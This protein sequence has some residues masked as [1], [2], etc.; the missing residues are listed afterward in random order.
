M[1]PKR[2]SAR[3][4][5]EHECDR[6]RSKSCRAS[7]WRSASPST[8][9]RALSSGEYGRAVVDA[10]GP[11]SLEPAGRRSRASSRAQ[12]RTRQFADGRQHPRSSRRAPAISS[13]LARTGPSF[14]AGNGSPGQVLHDAGPPTTRPMAQIATSPDSDAPLKGPCFAPLGVRGSAAPLRVGAKCW[15][16]PPSRLGAGPVGLACFEALTGP[17]LP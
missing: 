17:P 3:C 2:S 9:P 1:S 10:R 6:P 11:M 13:M 5:R 12:P 16:W 4:D 14:R 8:L 15:P 7:K